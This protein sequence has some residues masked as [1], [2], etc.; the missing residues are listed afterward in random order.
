V[1]Q[2]RVNPLNLKA[3]VTCNNTPDTDPL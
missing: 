1:N 3:A 2:L